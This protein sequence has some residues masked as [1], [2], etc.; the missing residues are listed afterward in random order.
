[1]CS[2]VGTLGGALH[3]KAPGDKQQDWYTS[4]FQKVISKE[5][6]IQHFNS[7]QFES[8]FPLKELNEMCFKQVL[9]F[10]CIEIYL[11]KEICCHGYKVNQK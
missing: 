3:A 1:M 6:S 10:C 9:T 11:N 4:Q 7:L 8:L 5:G 2:C